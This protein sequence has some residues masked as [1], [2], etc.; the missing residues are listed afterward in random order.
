MKKE[1]NIRH[2]SLLSHIL[3]DLCSFLPTRFLGFGSFSP[4]QCYILSVS[5]KVI[6]KPSQA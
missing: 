6:A 5:A 4:M 3:E 1:R 2:D